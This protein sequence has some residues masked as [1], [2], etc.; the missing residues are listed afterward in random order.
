MGLLL[1]HSV[2][3]DLLWAYTVLLLL[4]LFFFSLGIEWTFIGSN[5]S[6]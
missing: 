4:G 2:I 1:I 5:E 3:A 6:Q